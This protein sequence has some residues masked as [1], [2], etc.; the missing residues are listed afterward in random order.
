MQ[1]GM[2]GFP[3]LIRRAV[4]ALLGSVNGAV[5]TSEPAWSGA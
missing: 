2:Q 5:E 3:A 4:W 1:G